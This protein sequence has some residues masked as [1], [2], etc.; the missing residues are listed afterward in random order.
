MTVLP[1][2]EVKSHL[3]ELVGRVHDH[4]ER[5]T[6][7][8]HGRPAAVLVALEDL[9]QLEQTLEILSDPATMR[10]LAESDAE[11]ARGEEVTAEELA[12]T[13]RRRRAATA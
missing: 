7:T 3:S 13:M 4:H 12:D 11:L 5:V 9:E 2:G 10:R 8:V 1:L 6:V